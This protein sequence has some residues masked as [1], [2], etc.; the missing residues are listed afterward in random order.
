MSDAD[1]VRETPAPARH[2]HSL[3]VIDDSAVQRQHT[4]SLC[5]ALG[6]DVVYEACH[7]RDA[8]DQLAL[9]CLPPDLLLVDLHMPVMDGVEL[10]TQLQSLGLAIP[11]LIVSSQQTGIL[12]AVED[13]ARTLQLP[14]LGSLAKPV[15][16]Q[17]LAHALQ[18]YDSA[19]AHC[20]AQRHPQPRPPITAADLCGAIDAGQI[21][22]HY[23]P[24]VDM[25]T[26]L[27]RGMEVLA[28]WTHPEYGR[29]GPDQFIALAE[30]ENL[31]HDLTLAVL[32]RATQQAAAWRAHGFTPSLAIN[33]SPCLLNTPQVVSDI[34]RTTAKHQIAPQQL[35]LEVTESA[36]VAHLGQA[37]AL[38]TRLRLQ[39]FGLSLDDYGTGFSS[40]QQLARLPFTELKI[41]RSFVHGAHAR[42][43]LSVILESALDMAHRMSLTS[44]AEGI[45]TLE[46]WRL[47]QRH[48]CSVGQGYLIAK[49]MPAEAM[50]DWL[51]QHR[52]RLPQL[53]ASAVTQAP[54]PRSLAPALDSSARA[55]IAA[56]MCLTS[57]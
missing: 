24:K 7:G 16:P 15:H 19:L 53:R 36:G 35:V 3:M 28:R 4:A 31:I 20:V 22:V 14:L 54:H 56:P 8:L 32:D 50:P 37:I 9:L 47:L 29:I 10:I 30:A 41:D 1:F 38:L 42:R 48:G 33:L 43:N 52:T 5:R 51:R 45:E 21:D 40:M 25:R 23:Q 27:P 49:P 13:L 57:T 18:Q 12:T 39:G 17:A 55:V 6:V 11:L 44:V 2:V 26:G 34:A 46:D